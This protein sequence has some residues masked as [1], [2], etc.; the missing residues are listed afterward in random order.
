MNGGTSNMSN[1]RDFESE[2]TLRLLSPRISLPSLRDGEEV[3]GSVYTEVELITSNFDEL[4]SSTYNGQSIPATQERKISTSLSFND[5]DIIALG[6]LQ[7]VKQSN[8]ESQY[9]FFEKSTLFR[10]IIVFPKKR[11]L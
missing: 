10:Q 7:Q 4:G 3:P 6:G 2:T 8:S 9:S 5:N 1:N 11:E